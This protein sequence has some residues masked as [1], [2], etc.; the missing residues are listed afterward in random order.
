MISTRLRIGMRWIDT[1]AIYTI[2]EIPVEMYSG[3]GVSSIEM[4]SITAIV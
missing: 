4:D 1:E 2:A 3:I